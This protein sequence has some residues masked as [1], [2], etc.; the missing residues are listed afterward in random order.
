VHQ[1]RPPASDRPLAA[2]WW[3]ATLPRSTRLWLSL[4][5]GAVAGVLV[6]A[7][8][9][10]AKAVGDWDQCWIA[11][12]ALLQGKSPYAAVNAESSPWPL[13]YPLPAVLL[14]L[15]FTPL[16]LP[17]ARAAFSAVTSALLAYGLSTRWLG[18]LPLASGAYF[19]A[20]MGVQ[21]VP[22]LV[23]AVLLPWLGAVLVVKPTTGLVLWAGW[24]SRIAVIGGIVLLAASFA[25]EPGWVA[26]W[27][28]SVGANIVYH[29]SPVMRPFGWVLLLAL[30]RWRRPEGRFLTAFALIPQAA[31][32]YDALPLLLIP[33]TFHELVIF[34]AG[35]QLLA[36]V[37]MAKLG[38]ASPGAFAESLWPATLLFAYLPAL[39]MLLRAKNAPAEPVPAQTAL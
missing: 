3:T 11:G 26:K 13:I 18:L 29:V 37:G 27:R 22:L 30:L 6:W 28:T 8:D 1:L 38:A 19:W 9:I 32:P 17:L 31:M 39:V 16:P 4:A 14:S 34:V 20:L 10:D 23:A 2:G 33:R 25:V 15:P 24:P 5:I 21:W 36:V 7:Q 35:T 12:R